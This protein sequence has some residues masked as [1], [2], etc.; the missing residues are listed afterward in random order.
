MEI[1]YTGV[2]EFMRSDRDL[3]IL[4]PGWN[5]SSISDMVLL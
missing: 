1:A 5:F 3:A 2:N 4:R